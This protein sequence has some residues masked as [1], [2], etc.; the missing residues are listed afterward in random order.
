MSGLNNFEKVFG[1]DII[2]CNTNIYLGALKK[3]WK[4][5]ITMFIEK[6]KGAEINCRAGEN[7]L[8]RT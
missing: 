6:K 4:S 5:E 1:P 7:Y 3:F 2:F 8:K